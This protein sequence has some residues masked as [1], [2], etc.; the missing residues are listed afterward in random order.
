MENGH[1][2]GFTVLKMISV[3]EEVLMVQ[4]HLLAQGM[5]MVFVLQN[6]VYVYSHDRLLLL[7]GTELHKAKRSFQD[8]SFALDFVK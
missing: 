6:V 5:K 8:C 7:K 2:L 3:T 1:K 4:I